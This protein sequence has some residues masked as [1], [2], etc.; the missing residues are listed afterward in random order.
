MHSHTRIHTHKKTMV[1]N[2]RIH[3][4]KRSGKEKNLPLNLHV[5]FDKKRVITFYTGF[6]CDVNQWNNE[7]QKM[8]NNQVNKA[9]QS[10]AYINV[11][12]KAIRG[13]VDTWA[14]DNPTGTK[15]DLLKVLRAVAGKKEKVEVEEAPETIYSL[16]DKFLKERKLSKNRHEHYLVLKRCLQ[17]YEVHIKQPLTFEIDV[18]SF[19]NFL[20]IENTLN[21]KQ[22]QRGKNTVIG[23]IKKLR[24][25]VIWANNNGHTTVNPFNKYK[26]DEAK[27][28]T[29]FYLT[30]EE[31]KKLYNYDLSHRKDLEVQRDIFIFQCLVGCRVADLMRLTSENIIGN[32]LE[33]VATKTKDEQPATIR[34]PL[35][36]TALEI[37]KKYKG[38]ERL[39]PFT[40][41]QI[42]NNDIREF[43]TIC[44]LKRMVTVLDTKTRKDVQRPLNKVASSHIARRTFVGN[45]YSKVQDPNIVGSLSGHVEGSRAFARY[46]KIDDSIKANLIK[47]IE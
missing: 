29:P 40:N 15:D 37:I 10:S 36:K 45:L 6:R 30:I 31:R 41:P 28:G 12:L 22:K 42:Y 9:G 34:V 13:A 32:F 17:R 18:Q 8:K 26:I 43:F 21:E 5:F 4:E 2:S 25:F 38:G 47:S 44:G 24:S 33:Y 3:P 16:F 11:Q 19:E 39:F 20:T 14:K 7:D 27:Y 23:L 1:I 46:R 35:S